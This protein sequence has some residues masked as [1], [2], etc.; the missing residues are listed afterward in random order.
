MK[1]GQADFLQE[2]HDDRK[3]LEPP[4]KKDSDTDEE[5]GAKVNIDFAPSEKERGMTFGDKQNEGDEA[6]EME[7]VDSRWTVKRP[8]G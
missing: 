5:A 6:Q 4:V 2:M 7:M 8:P 3:K 1:K